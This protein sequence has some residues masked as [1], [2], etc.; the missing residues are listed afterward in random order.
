MY[1]LV[2]EIFEKSPNI[3]DPFLAAVI[4]SN[5][6]AT[7]LRSWRGD[8]VAI[9]HRLTPLTPEDIHDRQPV[10]GGG[11]RFILA[12]DFQLNDRDDLATALGMEIT[13]ARELSDSALALA[14]WERWREEAPVRLKGTFSFVVLDRAART[15]FV[16]CDRMGKRTAYYHIK[17]GRV[18]VAT[19]LPIVLRCPGVSR[20]PDP[21][22][23]GRFMI[24][25]PFIDDETP[26]REIR[27]VP[28]GTLLRIDSQGNASR[29]RYWQHDLEKRIIFARDD[30]YVDAALELMQRSVGNSSRVIGPL[31]SALSNGF[32]TGF[33]VSELARQNPDRRI[34]AITLA[35]VK[36][37]A[38][39]GGMPIDESSQAA[40]NAAHWD[41]V[42]HV[43]LRSEDRQNALWSTPEQ[44]FLDA[45][46]PLRSVDLH[47]WFQNIFTHT[48]SLNGRAFFDGKGGNAGFSW[49]GI[50]AIT[51]WMAQ[52]RW[53][54]ALRETFMLGPLAKE[55]S[56]DIAR[57]LW[58]LIVAPFSPIWL[59]RAIDRSR[60]RPTWPPMLRDS[61]LNSQFLYEHRIPDGYAA[62]GLTIYRDRP[63]DHRLYRKLMFIVARYSFSDH[64]EAMRLIHGIDM[65]SPLLDPDLL[66]F[67][68]AIPG[69][70]FINKGRV[71]WL[72]H[73][74]LA[75][76]LPASAFEPRHRTRQG[77]DRVT[78]LVANRD[79]YMGAL[80][81]ASS[82]ALFRELVDVPRLKN[83]L[84]DWPQGDEWQNPHLDQ[85]YGVA[86]PRALH[87]GNFLRW[88]EEGNQ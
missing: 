39:A 80:Q 36:S 85:A 81:N 20:A 67:C 15:I 42:D 55:G 43:T 28:Y 45:G 29:H 54:K 27:R 5:H 58:H 1:A 21:V 12:G 8:G 86:I 47:P 61:L 4:P 50:P 24:D 35:P 59:R 84:E 14:A 71:R 65:L 16:V 74:I 88:A 22:F 53:F 9:G 40:L 13:Q 25:D 79:N 32:D 6:G 62:N 52:G 87:I 3:D 82:S 68:M 11:D 60:H 49:N 17:Q 83:L 64:N 72:G 57:K 23:I 7:H 26:Y 51:P 2:A 77:G 41:N 56:P 78:T 76:R 34:K 75:N 10:I 66:Q 19:S 37:A 46:Y 70:Q 73:R 33:V 63:M 69:E 48:K 31:V 18:T 44:W 38:V 30:D